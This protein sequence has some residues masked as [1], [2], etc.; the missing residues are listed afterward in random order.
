MNNQEEVAWLIACK[1]EGALIG[2]F[3]LW[4]NEDFGWTLDPNKAIRFSRQQ[5][6][7]AV[8]SHWDWDAEAGSILT[9]EEHI[10]L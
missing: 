6:A 1:R 10:W 5:D 4:D 7:E 8:R 3:G 2:W 9:T